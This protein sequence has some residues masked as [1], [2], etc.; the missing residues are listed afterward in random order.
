MRVVLAKTVCDFLRPA[1]SNSTRA[2]Q[3]GVQLLARRSK[4]TGGVILLDKN[5]DP[6][7]AF[8]TPRMAY[9]FA[10][11]EAGFVTAV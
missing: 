7:Y 10:N 4:G 5:G 9:G 8:N 11:S 3:A 2:A 6:G 1:G